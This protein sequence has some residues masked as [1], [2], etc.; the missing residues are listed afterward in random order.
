LCLGPRDGDAAQVLGETGVGETFEFDDI[1]G[2]RMYLIN[3]Y[4][5]YRTSALLVKSKNINKY[6]R[7][8]LTERL[9]TLL[10]EITE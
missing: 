9:A 7:L 8:G 10:N 1:N 3:K 6:S 2:L 5:L 4:E